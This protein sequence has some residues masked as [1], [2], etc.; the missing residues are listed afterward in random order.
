VAARDLPREADTRPEDWRTIAWNLDYAWL[1][2]DEARAIVPEP[3]ELGARRD[4]PERVVRRLAR[5]YLRDFVRGEPIA[6]PPEALRSGHLTAEIA[7][8]DG[9]R[10]VLAVRGAVHLEHDSVWTRSEDRVERRYP[11]GYRC[12]LQG[13]ATWD[14]SRGAFVAFDLVAVGDRWGANQYNNREDDLGPAPQGIAFTLA[15]DAPSDRTPPHCIRT[16]QR[17][18]E[19]AR[20]SRVVVTAE[21]YYAPE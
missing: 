10:V 7:A 21:H 15:G 20:A 4:F 5:F 12:T 8:I 2:R 11:T 6:W 17:A 16:W 19:G 13:E 1:T 9:E 3:R 14:E 18:R